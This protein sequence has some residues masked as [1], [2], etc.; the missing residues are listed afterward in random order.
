MNWKNIT[1]AVCVG[2]TA[3]LIAY[4]CI[5][6]AEGGVGATISRVLRAAAMQYPI[7]AFAAGVLIG[8]LFWSQSGQ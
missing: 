7:I 3:A 2:T 6:D 1:V 4:D 5:A 8:H